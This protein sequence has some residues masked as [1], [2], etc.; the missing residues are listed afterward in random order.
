MHDTLFLVAGYIFSVEQKSSTKFL[1]RCVEVSA[2]SSMFY[3]FPP[4]T[5]RFS[6]RRRTMKAWEN[7][8]MVLTTLTWS[9]WPS[10]SR[11]TSC[12]SSVVSLPI[13]SGWTTAGLRLWSYARKT[14]YSRLADMI[15]CIIDR[16]DVIW[17][18]GS[19][20]LG[21]WNFIVMSCMWCLPY[22]RCMWPL[23]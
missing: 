20:W 22:R 5:C 8:S 9:L 14:S 3:F 1:E 16:C 10:R 2:C 15:V 23:L 12:W 11:N 7:P 13:C 21:L 19:T 4:C 6:L 18:L 17:D